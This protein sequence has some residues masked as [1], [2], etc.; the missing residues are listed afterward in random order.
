MADFSTH[1][2]TATAVGAVY[3]T[4]AT[5]AIGLDTEPALLL[6][7]LTAIGGILPDIDLKE[8]TPSKALFL[9]LGALIA[10][11]C[12]LQ[13]APRFSVI[14]L[15]AGGTI[16]FVGVRYVMW[17]IFHHFTVHRGSLHSIAA[18]VMFGIGTTALCHQAWSLEADTSW[19]A[20][21]GVFLGA[22]THLLLDELY[23]VDFSGVRVKRSFG[24]AIKIIDTV[25][26]PGSLAVVAVTIVAL[27]LAPPIDPLLEAV[28]SM[29]ENWRN[30]L[31]GT[32]TLR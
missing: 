18:C 6:A 30:W 10:L 21:I 32:S 17:S 31:I 2:F 28:F 25:R 11:L 24:S 29:D 12:M 20:G 26:W 4:V 27:T 3:T 14:E 7:A 22:V 5:K 1:F 13:Q 8:S 19:L 23:S 16:L 9:V 15:L